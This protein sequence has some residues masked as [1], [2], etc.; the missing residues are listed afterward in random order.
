MSLRQ[1]EA[2]KELHVSRMTLWRILGRY[3]EYGVMGLEHGLKGRASNNRRENP[4]KER[5]IRLCREKYY[6]CGPT[7][8]SEYL[9]EEGLRVHRETLRRWMHGEGI[10]YKTRKRKPYRQ[11]RPRKL[12]FG[13]MVQ[14]DG[15][16]HDWFELG[17][18]VCMMNL[19]DDASSTD[20]CRLD[21]EET[22]GCACLLLW[23]WIRMYGVPRCV[24][25]DKRNM[26]NPDNEKKNMFNMMCERLGIRLI[27]A[28]SSQAKGRVERSNRT[29]QD[30]LVSWLRLRG[31]KSIKGANKALP[32]YLAKHNSKFTID[33]GSAE[34]GHMRLKEG[35]RLEDYC[36]LEHPRKVS[37]DWVISY[38]GDKYQLKPQSIY[39]PAKAT[40]M[41]RETLSGTIAIFY[42]NQ[43]INYVPL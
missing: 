29:H 35:A 13:D 43:P 20:L 30:R 24:Y 18:D 21:E 17:E 14:L 42:R 15:S 11:R 27:L 39:C 3:R 34:D 8:A 19:I 41:V 32:E 22:I 2:C 31:I 10:M 38:N 37:N 28:N 16:F 6:D 25:T 5:I 12:R 4:D 23:D 40:V 36:Y 26:Y 33:P 9:E 1:A 7:L